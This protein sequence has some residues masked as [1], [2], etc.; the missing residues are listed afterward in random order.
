MQ[1]LFVHEVDYLRKPIYEIHEFAELLSLRKHAVS[2][3]DF[4]ES[5]SLK[6]R[7]LRVRRSTITGRVI[8]DARLELISPPLIFAGLLGRLISPFIF[9]V[10]FIRHIRR[11]RPDVI[12]NYSVPSS[13]WCV[14]LISRLMRIPVVYRAIDVPHL[15]RR[16]SLSWLVARAERIVCRNAKS[17]LANN[18]LLE[19]RCGA[20]GARH[21][22]TLAPGFEFPLHSSNVVQPPEY[23]CVFMGTLFRFSG[24][25]DLIQLLHD[26][27][28]VRE[29]SLLV[30]GD[31]EAS[32]SLRQ[33]VSK[34]HMQRRVTFVGAVPFDQ[35]PA[36]LSRAAVGVL[37]FKVSAVTEHALPAKAFQYVLAGLPVVSTPLAGLMEALRDGCGVKYKEMGPLFV[38]QIADLSSNQGQREQLVINGQSHIHETMNWTRVI[39]EFENLLRTMASKSR[40]EGT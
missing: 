36:Q 38:N 9:I 18:Q 24:L 35:L 31:G 26:N 30:I 7:R 22:A 32:D 8:P 40:D 10:V 5:E 19:K 25:N 4:P 28:A 34:L 27:T 11:C 3:I 33:L 14:V 20:L 17:V 16:T 2:F 13:G 21:T 6:S 12:V 15:L 23:D 29:L 37:P 39:E 1:V